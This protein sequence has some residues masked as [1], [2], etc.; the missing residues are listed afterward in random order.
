MSAEEE[1]KR[2]HDHDDNNDEDY[3]GDAKRCAL[4]GRW[5]DEAEKKWERDIKI[6]DRER[7]R[8]II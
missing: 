2:A 7:G 4:C 3:H 5:K 1:N 8:L 6:E